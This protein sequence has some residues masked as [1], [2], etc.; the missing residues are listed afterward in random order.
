M[1]KS[2]S[3]LALPQAKWRIR[4][5]WSDYLRCW[6][7]VERHS[8]SFVYASDIVPPEWRGWFWELISTDAP[9]SWGDNNHTLV[10]PG[11]FAD[12]A[13]NRLEA[14]VRGR[15]RFLERV[16]RLPRGVYINLESPA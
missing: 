8:V 13:A 16:R 1:A 15:Q 9:F 7:T 10:T 12:H 2:E 6:I 3:R 14:D 11:E 5:R 4:W